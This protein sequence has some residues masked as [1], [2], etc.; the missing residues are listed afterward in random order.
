MKELRPNTQIKQAYDA[1]ETLWRDMI[2]MIRP[3][4]ECIGWGIGLE[5]KEEYLLVTEKNTVTVQAGMCFYIELRID[6]IEMRKND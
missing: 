2:G 4:P 5:E 3:M 6:R 1:A